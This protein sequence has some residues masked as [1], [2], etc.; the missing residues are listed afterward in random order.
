MKKN[1][2]PDNQIA[3]YQTPDGSIN[4][5][6]LYAEENIWLTQKKMA[7]LFDCSAD[8]ISL[9]LKNLYQEREIDKESTTEEFSVVQ[10]EGDRKVSRCIWTTRKCK[11]RAVKLWL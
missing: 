8:N 11:R 6:V 7:E 4:I 5:E 1:K 9:H 3:F 2:I 10:E